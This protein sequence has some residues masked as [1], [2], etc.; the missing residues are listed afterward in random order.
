MTDG[1]ASICVI[2]DL[3]ET[4]VST[5][6]DLL[7]SI[8]R[9]HKGLEHY[10]LGNY[11]DW[12][13]KKH[14]LPLAYMESASNISSQCAAFVQH[15]KLCTGVLKVTVKKRMMSKLRDER[16]SVIDL[17]KV[18]KSHTSPRTNKD[19]F[20]MSSVIQKLSKEKL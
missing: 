11:G 8:L 20:F 2:V 14:F 1:L 19:A 16:V 4:R 9:L 10:F 17:H 15:E 7:Y 6:C 13:K 18:A 5:R 3:N 12:I